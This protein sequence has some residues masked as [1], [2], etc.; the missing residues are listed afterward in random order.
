M[1]N[2]TVS[3][4]R[5]LDDA[6]I[7]GLL[8][9]E[10]IT[11]NTAARLIINSDNRWSQ[12]AAVIGNITID[13]GTGGV[14]EVDGTEVWWIPYDAGTG[15]VPAL[16]V[17]GVNNAVGG[18]AGVGEF[19]GIFTALGVAPTA[20]AAAMPAVGFI[21]L[22]RYTVAFV[23]NEVIGLPGGA[24]VTVNSATGGVRGWIHVAGEEAST[25]TVPRVGKFE[26]FGDWFY[27]ANTSG[28]TDQV[29]QYYV[30]DQCPAL[31][32]ETG[33]GTGV[34]EWWL[35]AGTT[36]W[37]QANLRVAIDARGKFFGCSIVGAITLAT[38]V[39]NDCGYLPPAGCRVRVP[40]IHT[41]SAAVANWALNLRSTTL[42]TRWDFTTTSAGDV[43]FDR[44]NFC[45][46]PSINQ[47]YACI[48]TD[49]GVLD[50]VSVTECA[51]EPV[52]TRVAV[53]LSAALDQAAI[54]VASCF[55]GVSLIDCVTV[56]Y[57]SE[58]G[59][60]GS[61]I[62]DCD[63]VTVIGGIYTIFGDNTAA[64]LARGSNN[65]S[66][67][68]LNRCTNSTVDGVVVMGSTLRL[69]S[70]VNVA[71]IDPVY[72]DQIE[73]GAT[74]STNAV[75][76]VTI[77]T[78]SANCSVTGYGGNYL[79][80]VNVHP[81]NAL[82]SISA[83]FDNQVL[84]IAS[85][86]SPFNC[87][88]AN[89]CGGVVIYGGNSSGN[90]VRRCY[91]QNART[92]G[93]VD[94]NSDAR[95]T[96]WDVWGDG[97]DTGFVLNG[98]NATVR[99]ARSTNPITGATAVYGTH[100]YDTFVSTTEG[101][102]VFL[103]NEPTVL[104]GTK[105]QT[106]TGVSQFTST[107]QVKLVNL[108]DEITWEM[109]YYWLGI[110]SLTN[111]GPTFSGT[112]AANHTLEFQWDKNTGAGFNGSWLAATGA[113]LSGIGAIVATDGL[114]LK[115][116]ARCNT[117]AATNAIIN[118]R[119]TATTDAVSYVTQRPVGIDVTYSL[120]GLAVGT[121]VVLFDSSDVETDRQ[122][123]AGT[124]YEYDYFWQA[125][126]TGWYVL[127]W[128]GDKY[129]I[130]FTVGTLTNA[131]VA[132]P[133]T[134]AQDLVYDGALV[135]TDTTFDTVNKLQ[136]SDAGITSITVPRIYSEWKNWLR[137]TNNAQFDFAYT[138][139]GG[140]VISGP[141]SIPRY[142]FQANGWKYRPQEANHT[143]S[144]TEGI[145]VGESGSDPFVNTLAA[146]MVRILFEQPVQAIGVSANSMTV[147]DVWTHSSRTLTAIGSS[148]IASQTS[149]DSLGAPLQD[150]DYTAPDNGGIADIKK[151]VRADEVH[152]S[153]TGKIQKLEE[154]TVTVLLEKDFTGTPLNNFQAVQP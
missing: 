105:L 138:V 62:T 121:E 8:N 119:V 36:R 129:P 35:C 3:V 114:K 125:D 7:A 14:C 38:R 89:A 116:R 76:G 24:T 82:V 93:V 98:L 42:G 130:R 85:A 111:V 80:L 75:S 63:N 44:V 9:G 153:I 91:V 43:S 71:V 99:G 31:Q 40:N 22:R 25:I 84:D 123:I 33:V 78:A 54:S 72:C 103:G 110:T 117:A 141:K 86:A 102:L 29:I 30:A 23:D 83:S 56:R 12:Q 26:A 41:C 112:N 52:L 120:T 151:L 20:A 10:D 45:S 49:C 94:T 65:G 143:L 106:T 152:N 4:D 68:Q 95:N 28:A 18:V 50:Q 144:I 61:T 58:T 137:L 79:S 128:K 113:N 135:G 136:I 131:D 2:Q 69:T 104:S 124:V 115:F 32:I 139:V 74:T 34:Y 60:H 77:E 81:Y 64:T 53:G 145:L 134:Q 150:V 19:L 92:G 154:G 100:F 48:M 57:E 67:L 47:S 142:V 70:C 132:I 148:G 66:A 122:V 87:G 16:G 118:I 149:V 90:L 37:A 51:T 1:A 11:I 147:N 13:S 133:I 15:N 108:N 39:G 146:F 55:S 96:A 140:D 73:G 101:R 59:D 127:I 21:K 17:L 109:D 88:S 5:N 107:G 46:Y 126:T 6:A 97:A 27:L